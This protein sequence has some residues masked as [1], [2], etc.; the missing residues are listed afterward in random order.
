M[1][2]ET[3]IVRVSNYGLAHFVPRSTHARWLLSLRFG[4]RRRWRRFGRHFGPSTA[5]AHVSTHRNETTTTLTTPPP[6]SVVDVH[7]QMSPYVESVWRGRQHTQQRIERGGQERC[8]RAP[9]P[10]IASLHLAPTFRCRRS[11]THTHTHMQMSPPADVRQF[12]QRHSA[13]IQRHCCR[14]HNVS[15]SI[16]SLPKNLS[17][18]SR[19]LRWRSFCCLL[20][21]LSDDH[22]HGIKHI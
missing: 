10:L 3:D 16:C 21:R 18:K 1:W 11:H 7:H 4:W 5:R 9:G 22:T 19:L 15:S 2:S 17:R 13:A 8:Q 12:K 14:A 6:P 20:S